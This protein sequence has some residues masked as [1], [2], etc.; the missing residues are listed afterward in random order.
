MRKHE[1][2]LWKP[3]QTTTAIATWLLYLVLAETVLP[4]ELHVVMYETDPSRRHGGGF[5]KQVLLPRHF[6]ATCAGLQYTAASHTANNTLTAPPGASTFDPVHNKHSLA[7]F[8]SFTPHS[9]FDTYD[10]LQHHTRLL[11]I[12][13]AR[14][15]WCF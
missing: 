4:R 14:H 9:H 1:A 13:I 10:Y 7:S 6:T 15:V 5:G 11:N 3:Q 8:T 12:G 2:G